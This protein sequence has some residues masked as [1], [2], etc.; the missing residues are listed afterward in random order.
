MGIGRNRGPV[1]PILNYA[2]LNYLLEPEQLRV[3]HMRYGV[4]QTFYGFKFFPVHRGFD[5][6]HVD[7]L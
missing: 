3:G 5:A 1:I 7:Y 2:S 4:W 6:R